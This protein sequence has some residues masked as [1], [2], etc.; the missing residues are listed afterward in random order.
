MEEKKPLGEVLGAFFA[1]KGFY[2][3]LFLC[4]GLIAASIWLMTDRSGADAEAVG[5]EIGIGTASVSG[6]GA[7]DGGAVP[8][9]NV[10]EGRA[11]RPAA[12]TGTIGETTGAPAIPAPEEPAAAELPPET[13]E[14]AAVSAGAAEPIPAVD[15]FIWPVNGVLLRG[16]AIETLSYDRTMADWRVHRGWDIAAEP[17]AQVLAAANGQ[18]CACYEDERL[19]TVV[20]V[21]HS[22]GLVS[23]YANLA[24]EV[25]VEI[26]QVVPVGGVLGTVGGT[27]LSESGQEAHLHFALRRDGEDVDPAGWLPAP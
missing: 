20:E 5:G 22:N 10:D 12:E 9:M 23:V 7:E 6:V 8:A 4:A 25:P 11:E 2:I 18:V 1:G 15:Y 21:R 27:A 3:V 13:A 17:G 19:G 14:T 24:A 26:G 16:F